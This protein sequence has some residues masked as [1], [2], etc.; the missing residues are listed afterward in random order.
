[1]VESSFDQVPGC[2]AS[3]LG[4]INYVRCWNML[5]ELRHQRAKFGLAGGVAQV[6]EYLPSKFEALS[7]NPSTSNK[8]KFGLGVVV[9]AYTPTTQEAETEESCLRPA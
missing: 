2:L 8:I 6:V 3:L 4:D 5:S 9:H 1:M 7:S